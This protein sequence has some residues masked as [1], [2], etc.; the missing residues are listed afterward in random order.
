MIGERIRVARKLK[1]W[2]MRELARRAGVSAQAISNY[3]RGEDVPG[4]Q[5]LIRIAL[6]V[7]KPLEFFFTRGV[8]IKEVRPAYRKRSG[9]SR[10]QQQSVEAY[11]C[12]WAGRVLQVQQISGSSFI[13]QFPEGFPRQIH[14]IEEVE[15]A[16]VHLREA[17]DL[18]MD[19]IPN[20]VA[21]LE[22]K[23]VLIGVVPVD[24]GDFDGAAF[25]IRA[26]DSASCLLPAIAVRGG[27][28]GDRQ[29]FTLS[30]ELFHLL[31]EVSEGLDAER[32]A[33]RFAAAFLVPEPTAREVLGSSRK[34]LSLYELHLLKHQFGLSMLA[35]VRRAHE[36]QIIHE[37][38]AQE[39]FRLFRKRG[40]HLQ[41]P[42][43]PYPPEEPQRFQRVVVRLY[44]EGVI[45]QR[46]AEY[47]LAQPLDAFE[48]R[49]RETH[50]GLE[51]GL[52]RGQLSLDQLA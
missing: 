49:V 40:W 11:L 38:T 51:I 26:D 15:Q 8:S 13:W 50:G 34:H 52:R 19:A 48:H 9:L 3:E 16:A 6:A 31:C 10:A 21:L 35:W 2:S 7:E 45:S 37:S 44:E 33:H 36:L 29:R 14:A 18:G 24:A 22:E 43:D 17:W 39:M 47:L 25:W 42:G 12:D 4:S 28:P 46:R 5:V 41:E 27:L 30:H 20:L 1:G 23:G 32:M